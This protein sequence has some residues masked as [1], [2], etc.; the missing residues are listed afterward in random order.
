M[1]IP[2]RE[3]EDHEATSLIGEERY[4]LA[5]EEEEILIH[6]DIVEGLDGDDGVVVGIL[7]LEQSRCQRT[8]LH[9]EDHIAVVEAHTYGGYLLGK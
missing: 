7:T 5:S 9:L 6:G 8:R 3:L 4:T 2:F 1:D